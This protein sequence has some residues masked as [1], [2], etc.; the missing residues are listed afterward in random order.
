[1]HVNISVHIG[2]AVVKD[3]ADAPGGKEVVGGEVLS[4][5]DWAPQENVDAVHLTD[6]ARG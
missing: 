3:S 6:A 5:A 1:V 4:T 2:G